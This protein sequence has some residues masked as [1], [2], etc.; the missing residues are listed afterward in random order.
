MHFLKDLPSVAR[1]LHNHHI[2]LSEVDKYYKVIQFIRQ[3]KL[4]FKYYAL[5]HPNLE[6]SAQVHPYL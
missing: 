3:M 2:R 6:A 5:V 4:F 1:R